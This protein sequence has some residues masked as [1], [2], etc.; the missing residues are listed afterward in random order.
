MSPINQS[1]MH[2][3]RYTRVPVEILEMAVK[4]CRMEAES[5]SAPTSSQSEGGGSASPSPQWSRRCRPK[6]RTH[7]L[8][9]QQDTVRRGTCAVGED[10]EAS[11]ECR[12]RAQ[13]TRRL[14]QFKLWARNGQENPEWGAVR[15]PSAASTPP[16]LPCL[17]LCFELILGAWGR[18]PI[19]AFIF[20]FWKF[21]EHL[22]LC[23]NEIEWYWSPIIMQIQLFSNEKKK[24]V[25]LTPLFWFLYIIQCGFYFLI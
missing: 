9:Q 23:P 15:E 18:G 21:L 2:T 1:T 16:G 25:F 24:T 20:I 13:H 10:G 22:R 14:L 7:A 12:E 4:R 6:R 11:G 8:W 3:I 19:A 5:T 17:G